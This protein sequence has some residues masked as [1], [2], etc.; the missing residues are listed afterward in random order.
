ML[1][2]TAQVCT[3]GKW[4][5]KAHICRENGGWRPV[6][7]VTDHVDWGYDRGDDD[8][9]DSEV[10]A[11]GGARQAQQQQQVLTT[12]MMGLVEGRSR[13]RGSPESQA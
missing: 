7:S 8:G 4:P 2:S 6:A 11:D 3:V 9:N 12:V 1:R 10:A 5:L 13:E